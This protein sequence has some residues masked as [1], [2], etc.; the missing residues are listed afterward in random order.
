MLTCSAL[1]QLTLLIIGK[2]G[3]GS[4]FNWLEP[5]RSADGKM[6]I[7]QALRTVSQNMIAILFVLKW[8]YGFSVSNLRN[9]SLLV[10]TISATTSHEAFSLGMFPNVSIIYA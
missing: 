6:T 4:S 2:C 5:P 7:Q 8:H 10:G 3:F 9:I 1:R